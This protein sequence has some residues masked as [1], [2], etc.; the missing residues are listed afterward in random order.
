MAYFTCQVSEIKF[1]FT[2]KNNIFGARY[3]QITQILLPSLL[4]VCLREIYLY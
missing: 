1:M 2:K 4:G 3:V